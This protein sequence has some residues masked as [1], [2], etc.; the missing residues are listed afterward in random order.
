MRRADLPALFF[1]QKMLR[2]TYFI[3]MT[4]SV[5]AAV[6]GLGIIGDGKRF[7]GRRQ[8]HLSY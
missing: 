8:Y 4:A 2:R 3:S 1:E 6:V 5:F 7:R